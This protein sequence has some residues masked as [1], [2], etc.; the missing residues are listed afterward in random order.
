MCK[1]IMGFYLFVLSNHRLSTI[2]MV[3]ILMN[4]NIRIA[5]KDIVL[6]YYWKFRKNYNLTLR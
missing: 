2:K 1:L 6:T 4:I 5:L 3:A